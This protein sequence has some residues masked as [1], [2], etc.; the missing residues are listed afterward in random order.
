[1]KSRGVADISGATAGAA[2]KARKDGAEADVAAI[3]AKGGE[4]AAGWRDF[5]AGRSKKSDLADA[6][7]M[8][9]RRI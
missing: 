2:Y 6:F 3:L 4:G 5:F 1:V 7:L 9:Y 8:A